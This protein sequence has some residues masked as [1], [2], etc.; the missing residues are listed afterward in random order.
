MYLVC[1]WKT[2][3]LIMDESSLLALSKSNRPLSVADPSLAEFYG[4]SREQLW[5]LAPDGYLHIT[6]ANF[7]YLDFAL[8]WVN[9][10]KKAGIT[11][12]VVGCMDSRILLELNA[13]SIPTIDMHVGVS[14][15]DLGWGSKEFYKAGEE[16]V[17]LN[18]AV[19]QFGVTV[20]AQDVD[21]LWLKD[22]TEFWERYPRADLFCS[23]DHYFSSYKDD[24]LEDSRVGT[25]ANT[26]LYVLRPSAAEFTKEWLEAIANDELGWEQ[27][28]F[29]DV[30]LQGYKH[31]DDD[32]DR[33]FEVYRGKLLMGL[34]PTSTFT[35]GHPYFIQHLPDKMGYEPYFVHAT[36][37]FFGVTGKRHRLRDAFL[38]TVDP[39]E[40]YD[41]PGGFL[42][43]DFDVPEDLLA[44]SPP[45]NLTSSTLD[46]VQGHFNLINHQLTQIR[47]ALAIA[48]VLKRTL[49]FNELWCGHDRWWNSHNGLLP[50]VE[51]ELPF[52]CPLDYILD[53]KA[54]KP[55]QTAEYDPELEPYIDFR[56]SSFLRNERLPASVRESEVR[57]EICESKPNECANGVGPAAVSTVS[58]PPT[59]YLSANLTDV[60]LRKALQSVGSK[61]LLRFSSMRNT[62]A[63]F[64]SPREAAAFERTVAKWASIWCCVEAVENNFGHVWLDLFHDVL[65]HTDVHGRLW[66]E[67]HPWIPLRGP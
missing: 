30:Y 6:S 22:P 50:K 29:W 56:E 7:H 36:F 1:V 59:V 46:D 61:R 21:T 9:H 47:N 33:L 39:P 3:L 67:T 42:A 55:E 52:V 4:L 26:G 54:M 38:W 64:K 48:K 11:S 51:M 31:L 45:K 41:T 57:V 66:N 60:E 44:R 32:P 49:I 23:S 18:L 2:H 16:M 10:I 34:L 53:L 19:L 62:F 13:R 27:R 15:N 35:S 12:Y 25:V 5:Q 20:I 8:N 28:T 65:P 24:G 63:G 43:W 37:Q 58:K 14:K 40:Y 17:R